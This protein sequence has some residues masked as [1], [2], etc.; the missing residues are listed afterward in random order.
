MAKIWLEMVIKLS[1]TSRKVWATASS[2]SMAQ[3]A[4]DEQQVK[5]LRISKHADFDSLG[6][7]LLYCYSL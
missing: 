7:G 4:C 2:L 5:Q 6:F 3:S 1:F